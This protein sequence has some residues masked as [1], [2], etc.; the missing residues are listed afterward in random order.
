MEGSSEAGP[1]FLDQQEQLP[2]DVHA[3]LLPSPSR[4]P[5]PNLKSMFVYSNSKPS[6]QR[7]SHNH[8]V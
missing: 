5:A 8:D 4:S 1:S 2:C 7:E 6:K 3:R